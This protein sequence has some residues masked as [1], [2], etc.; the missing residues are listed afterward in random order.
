MH[1]TRKW[2]GYG[3][4]E[5][6]RARAIEGVGRSDLCNFEWEDL[7][8]QNSASQVFL[9]NPKSSV[10]CI[11]WRRSHS[12]AVRQLLCCRLGI[13]NRLVLEHIN[14]ILDD[15]DLENIVRGICIV[16]IS[17]LT[18]NRYQFGSFPIRVNLFSERRSQT[19]FLRTVRE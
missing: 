13:G 17:R 19:I 3:E 18:I 5:A 1:V 6:T 4:E 8:V 16:D 7:C 11:K 10:S 12:Q 14:F 9:T 15:L 2:E